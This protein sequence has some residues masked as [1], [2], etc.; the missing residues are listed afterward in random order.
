MFIMQSANDWFLEEKKPTYSYNIVLA[1]IK[2]EAEEYFLMKI[3]QLYWICL[4]IKRILYLIGWFGWNYST[5]V[6][7]SN[8]FVVY[9]YSRRVNYQ[10]SLARNIK[11]FFTIYNIFLI[12][13]VLTNI[14]FSWFISFCK[15]IWTAI[16]I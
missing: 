15:I 2:K 13:W 1:K 4:L 3:Y 14:I 12:N 9:I 7:S 11:I 16:M 10:I 8:L 6:Q 5:V